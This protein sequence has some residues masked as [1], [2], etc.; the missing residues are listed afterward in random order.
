MPSILLNIREVEEGGE[1]DV[2]VDDDFLGIV[3]S[4]VA[5]SHKNIAVGGEGSQGGDGSCPS[6]PHSPK[7][8][9]KAFSL[10]F[11]LN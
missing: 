2:V 1:H 10:S 8:F 11:F 4:A 6:K 5:P 9:N 3:G 7:G